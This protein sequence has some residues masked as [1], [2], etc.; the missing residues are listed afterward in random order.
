MIQFGDLRIKKV[1]LAQ[2]TAQQKAVML[3]QR[4][5]HGLRQL[6]ALA[7]HAP[8]RQLGKPLRIILAGKQGVQDGPARDPGDIAGHRRHLHLA[9]LQHLLHAI[10]QACPFL[11]QFGALARQLAQFPLGTWGHET[12]P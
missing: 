3:P 9:L 5:L 2:L 12:G 4:A 6:L 7:P 8:A 1:E 11:H 10:D